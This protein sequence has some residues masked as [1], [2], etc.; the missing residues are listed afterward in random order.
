MSEEAARKLLLREVYDHIR[1]GI[2]E[3][4]ARMYHGELINL[5]ELT[6]RIR[7]RSL[8]S[9]SQY[10]DLITKD[11]DMPNRNLFQDEK[12]KTKVI[13]A[14]HGQADLDFDQVI[15]ALERLEEAGILF[16]EEPEKTERGPRKKNADGT[17]IAEDGEVEGTKQDTPP[18]DPPVQQ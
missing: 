15:S 9:F 8:S 5:D 11:D 2:L 12:T 14:L 6:L 4:D 3:Y 1:K 13:K 17:E 16:A 18:V 7:A 10:L